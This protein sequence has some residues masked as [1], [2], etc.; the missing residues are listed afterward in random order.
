MSATSN[1]NFIP[2]RQPIDP[3][4]GDILRTIEGVATMLGFEYLLVG[5]TARDLIFINVFGLTGW[6][7]TRDIDFGVATHHWEAF[8]VFRGAVLD[9]GQFDECVGRIH[10]LM[11]KT[12]SGFAMPVNLIPFG[13]VAVPDNTIA[14]PPDRDFIMNVAG[15]TEA[16]DA[17]IHVTIGTD[18]SIRVASIPALAILKLLAWR[19]RGHEQNK[20][21]TDLARI[22]PRYAAAGNEDRLYSECLPL[23]EAADFDIEV[24]GA[25]LLGRDA[26]AI[27]NAGTHPQVRSVLDSEQSIDRLI[28]QMAQLALDTDAET[29]QITNLIRAFRKGFLESQPSLQ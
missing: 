17:A 7:A 29:S 21:A 20:D 4:I 15:F 6:R 3:L 18:L 22:L 9:T 16:L 28:G 5:A 19:D 14:W 12:E 8:E 24:A 13:G 27:C 11:Y 10:R 1:P 25:M 26:S 23:L 2:I